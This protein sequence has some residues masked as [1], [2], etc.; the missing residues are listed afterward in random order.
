MRP[1]IAEQEVLNI[2]RSL[3]KDLE[4]STQKTVPAFLS[5]MP[6]AYFE[7]L[8]EA[9]IL[10]HL[11]AIVANEATGISQE[12]LL[13]NEAQ[14]TYT[15]IHEKNYRGQLS[16]LVARLP[17]EK[18][19]YSAKVYSA[20]KSDLIVDV[21]RMGKHKFADINSQEL[22]TFAKDLKNMLDE[23]EFPGSLDTHLDICNAHYLKKVKAEVFLKDWKLIERLKQVDETFVQIGKPQSGQFELSIAFPHARRRWIMEQAARYLGFNHW[24]IHWATVES[25]RDIEKHYSIISFSISK[26]ENGSKSSPWQQLPKDL[27]RLTYLDAHI[28]ELYFNNDHLNLGET[29]LIYCISQ[30]VHQMLN[31]LNPYAFTFNRILETILSYEDIT[32]SILTA[33]TYKFNP[34]QLPTNSFPVFSPEIDRKVDNEEEQKIMHAFGKVV[35]ATF[36]TNFYMPRR[37]S[38]AFRFHPELLA[39][40]TRETLPFGVFFISG[41]DFHA[42]HVRFREI[43][44]GGIRI[45]RPP[46]LTQYTLESERLYDEAYNLALAQQLKNKDIPEGGSKGVILAHPGADLNM[47]GM[48]F[49]DALLDLICIG[50]GSKKYL[51]DYWGKDEM[52]YLGPDENISD[53]L[54]DWIVKRAANRRYSLPNAFMSSKPGAGINHKQYGVTSEGVMVFLASALKAIGRDPKKDTFSLKLTGGPDGDVAGNVIKILHKDYGERGKILGIADGSGTLEDPDGIHMSELVRLAELGLGVSHFKKECLGQRGSL[55]LT[56]SPEGL[57]SRNTLHNRIIADAFI[58]AGGRPNSINEDNWE[59]YLDK[60]GKPTSKIIIEGANLFITPGAREKLSQKGVII[61]KDSSA[62]KCGVICSSYEIL[63]SMLVD[64]ATF[65]KIKPTFIDEVMNILR[66]LANMEAQALLREHRH[67]PQLSL[68]QLSVRLSKAIN[69]ASDAIAERIPALNSDHMVLA[70]TWA[71]AH[72]PSILKIGKEDKVLDMLPEAYLY[73]I[74]ATSLA[75]T[76]IYREGM[77]YFEEMEKINI[78]QLAIQ[79]LEKEKEINTYIEEISNSRL[80]NKARIIQLLKEGAPGTALKN[81]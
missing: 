51:R 40:H 45:V 33:F 9:T 2:T 68:P 30:L 54:I 5:D 37:Y 4:S 78:Y 76:I 39:H 14:N 72:I 79:Y 53:H 12:I 60:A 25:F 74:I 65:L 34:D 8:D 27:F 59:N 1:T 32:R 7:D 62:N 42:F 66:K 48:A 23:K 20:T 81:L 49:A 43:A 19:L 57:V 6:Q 63:S 31:P 26:E 70:R 73:Q 64:E 35:T 52:I 28:L 61:F 3:L 16:E 18:S 67:Q 56:D 29:E 46:H 58:P 41:K 55:Q 17:R 71:M 10:S 47:C 44:R 24:N 21:F 36:K 75:S 22:K 50:P 15:F 13:Y 69:K 80:S 77:H 11:K 38:L